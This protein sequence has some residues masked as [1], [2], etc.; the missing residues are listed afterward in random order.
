MRFHCVDIWL[1]PLSVLGPIRT[2]QVSPAGSHVVSWIQFSFRRRCLFSTTPYRL[3][4]YLDEAEYYPYRLE[5]K[6][7]NTPRQ[8]QLLLQSRD[9]YH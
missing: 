8:W 7:G 2:I 3:T 5:H 4:I 6:S 9:E 1:E